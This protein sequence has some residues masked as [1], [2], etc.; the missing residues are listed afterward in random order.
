MHDWSF[1]SRKS[2]KSADSVSFKIVRLMFTGARLKSVAGR[3]NMNVF[4]RW[5]MRRLEESDR[6]A[7]EETPYKPSLK[8]ELPPL[9]ETGGEASIRVLVSHDV[10][11]AAVFS[12]MGSGLGLF[13]FCQ[14][15]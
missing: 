14:F 4:R 6:I 11:C 5:L 13:R 3:T 7:S 9:D 8:L 1:Y 15:L 2:V 12:C 10:P